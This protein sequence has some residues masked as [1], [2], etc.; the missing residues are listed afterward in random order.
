[1]V[2]TQDDRELTS[3]LYRMKVSQMKRT[4]QQYL[5]DAFLL[6]KQFG[7]TKPIDIDRLGDIISM[8]QRLEDELKWIEQY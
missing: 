5:W 2:D 6:G 1:M 8:F 3:S 7:G 4:C